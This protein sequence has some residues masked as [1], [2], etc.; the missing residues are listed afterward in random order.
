MI[1]ALVTAETAPLDVQLW[2][3]RAPQYA[4]NFT[5]AEVA[6]VHDDNGWHVRWT[7]Q[8]GN[9]RRFPLGERVAVRVE[10]AELLTGSDAAL[11]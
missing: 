1:D 4:P 11:V 8:N 3:T 10:N 7:Y 2:P 5:L 9:T 6:L